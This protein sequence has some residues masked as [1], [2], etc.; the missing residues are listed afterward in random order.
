MVSIG[1][2][3]TQDYKSV[4]PTEWH[5]RMNCSVVESNELL[6]EQ[7]YENCIYFILVIYVFYSRC[8]NFDFL[9]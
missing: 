6:E 8:Q 3:P 5:T 2:Y 4:L 1:I 7:Y 9:L